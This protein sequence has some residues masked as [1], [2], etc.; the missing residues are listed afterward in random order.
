MEVVYLAIH[1]AAKNTNS[2]YS[3]PQIS[4]KSLTLLVRYSIIYLLARGGPALIN[5]LALAVYTRLL[6][7]EQYGQYA[8]VLAGVALVQVVCF[9]WLGLC[10]ARFLPANHDAPERFL[11]EIKFLFAMLA[12]V[13][14]AVGL[15]VALL[16]PDPVWQRLVA[17]AV[18]LLT[19]HAWFELNL[20]YAAT[21]DK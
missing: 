20:N 1:A 12:L 5:F 7:P 2:L 18:P 16:W 14:S 11:S 13:F 4:L 19:V 10:L 6:T 21:A 17:L 9:Q 3:Y 8:L 15:V